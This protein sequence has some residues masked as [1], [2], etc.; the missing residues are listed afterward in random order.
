MLFKKTDCFRMERLIIS[1][2]IKGI[3]PGKGGGI[4]GE[5]FKS[6]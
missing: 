4:H 6:R 2:Y 5:T 1:S 3:A